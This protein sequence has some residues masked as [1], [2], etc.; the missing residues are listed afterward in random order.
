[1]TE[2]RD[3]GAFSP[4]ASPDDIVDLL[5]AALA[6]AMVPRTLHFPNPSADRFRTALL[7][8]IALMLG[9]TGYRGSGLDSVT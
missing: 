3:A 1:V 2:G 7:R 4:V 6:G 8:Q 5:L 9:R